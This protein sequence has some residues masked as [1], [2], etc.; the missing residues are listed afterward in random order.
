MEN[1]ETDALGSWPLSSK[2]L[3]STESQDKA[4]APASGN[5]AD[6]T[7]KEEKG[8]PLYQAEESRVLDQK[9]NTGRKEQ[10]L[11]DLPAEIIEQ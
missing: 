9:L 5:D 1:I 2:S 6:E 11:A 10:S 4:D 3:D 8:K 7:E